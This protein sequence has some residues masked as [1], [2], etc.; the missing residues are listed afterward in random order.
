M[1]S[2]GDR[3]CSPLF[4]QPRLLLFCSAAWPQQVG[5]TSTAA[6]EPRCTPPAQNERI[7]RVGVG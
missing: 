7:L 3:S 2:L 6:G 1:E 4:A 5:I